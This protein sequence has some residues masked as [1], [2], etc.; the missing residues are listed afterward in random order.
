M[1][2]GALYALYL[3]IS[4]KLFHYLQLSCFLFFRTDTVEPVIHVGLESLGRWS[5]LV[6]Q[7]MGSQDRLSGTTNL[8]S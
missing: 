8:L 7:C 3:Y 4:M 1:I 5:W 6:Q 2:P